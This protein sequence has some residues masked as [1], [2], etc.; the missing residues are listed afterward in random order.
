[1]K[2]P[3]LVIIFLT[4]IAA[5]NGC[6]MSGRSL[7]PKKVSPPIAPYSG[8][9]ARVVV[10]EF[11]VKAAKA[12]GEIGSGLREMFISLLMDSRRFSVLE[13]QALEALQKEQDL[14]PAQESAEEGNLPKKGRIKSAEL[15]IAAAVTEFEP[16]A[17]GGSAGIGGGGGIASGILGGLLGAASNKA[18]LA[19]DIRLI[20]ASTSEIVAAVHVQGQASDVAGGF[21]AGFLANWGLAKGLSIYANTPM[22]KAIRICI[23]EAVRSLSQAIPQSYYK[24]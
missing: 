13:R 9:K 10:A 23:I 17:S 12:A 22:E 3:F 11:E 14:A 6:A 15:V 4:V 21:M 5:L 19:L 16:Q 1:M 20:D 2:R 8:P 24:Y 18:H 7:R